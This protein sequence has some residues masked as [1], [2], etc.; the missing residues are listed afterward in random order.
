[1]RVL[2]F[3]T[4]LSWRGGEQ[5]LAYLVECMPKSVQSLIVCP[6]KSL[7]A[8]H[9]KRNELPLRLLSSRRPFNPSS[10]REFGKA[11]AEF[12]PT[13]IH[14]HDPD[15]QAI[16]VLWA[17]F[18]RSKI[19]MILSRKVDFPIKNSYFTR[20]KYNF[21]NIKRIICVSGAV[22]EI[23]ASAIEDVSKLR[24][25]YDAIDLNRFG[26]GQKRTLR[27]GY[28]IPDDHL[29]VGNIGALVPHKDYVTFINTADRLIHLGLKARFFIIGE[30]PD[31]SKLIKMIEDR[32]LGKQFVVTG[33]RHDIEDVFPE[34]DIFLHP[35]ETEGLGS[36]ILDA[37]VCKVAVVATRAGG[38][39]EIVKEEETGLLA[40]VK[41]SDALAQQVMRLA[42]NPE[43]RHRLVS[44]AWSFVQ[45]FSKERFAE[46]HLQLYREVCS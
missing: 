25:I 46:R 14:L 30:G 26:N 22:R 21:S 11:V 17:T 43:L 37:F 32:G 9:A 20:Y 7:L 13:L 33:F 6:A 10:W 4:P 8:R 1:M 41:D 3:S 19:P 18:S 27:D 24:L 28:R 16:A 34:L 40:N 5:Q 2:H 23:V 45:D 42:E 44:Q 29:I 39:V 35:S 12:K 38:I 31:K 36:S 15:A